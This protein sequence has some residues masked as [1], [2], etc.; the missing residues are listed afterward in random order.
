[1][2]R[3]FPLLILLLLVGCSSTPPVAPTK[4]QSANEK[5]WADLNGRLEG[6]TP[7]QRAQYIKEHPDEMAKLAEAGTP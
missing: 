4:A 7:E 1:M 3:S 2:V 6:M 5:E